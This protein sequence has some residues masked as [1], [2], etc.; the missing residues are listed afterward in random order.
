MEGTTK[1][2]KD[3]CSLMFL[4]EFGHVR[5]HLSKA[6]L[7]MFIMTNSWTKVKSFDRIYGKIGL[8]PLEKNPKMLVY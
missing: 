8:I 4:H 5:H 7:K 6:L 3:C 1:F 2:I